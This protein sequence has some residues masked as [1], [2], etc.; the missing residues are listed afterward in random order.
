MRLALVGVM[1]CVFCIACGADELAFTTVPEF[2]VA[3]GIAFC[4]WKLR[5]GW[6]AATD[7]SECKG[8]ARTSSQ[9]Y[10]ASSTRLEDAV[11]KQRSIFDLDAGRTCLDTWQNAGCTA[12]H[13]EQAESACSASRILHGTLPSG[14]NCTASSDC[15]DGLCFVNGKRIP[16]TGCTGSCAAFV[17]RGQACDPESSLC[18]LDT[19]FCDPQTKTCLQRRPVGELCSGHGSCIEGLRCVIPAS[20][21]TSASTCQPR[22]SVN[23]SCGVDSMARKEF[24]FFDSTL[25]TSCQLGLYCN[26]DTFHCMERQTAGSSCGQSSA[27]ADGLICNG[28]HADP[29]DHTKRLRDGRCAPWTDLGAACNESTGPGCP[30]TMAC[31]KGKQQ[32]LYALSFT[33]DSCGRMLDWPCKA[34]TFCDPTTR[35]CTPLKAL[36]EVC[37]VPGPTDRNPC[38]DGQCNT[39]TNRCEFLC[40]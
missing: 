2:Q 20:G 40:G 17:S 13:R 31:D 14:A 32:C 30:D 5:C 22:G 26:L 7:S 19:D 27:C 16:S 36:G 34:Y 9:L 33:G 10:P 3:R 35:R 12:N 39:V 29:T 11:E 21:N 8:F 25:A 28:L 24:R 6:I 23:M 38:Y 1:S 37:P 4:N 15:A 18:R